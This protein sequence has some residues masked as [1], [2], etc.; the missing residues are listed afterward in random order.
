[1]RSASG[2]LACPLGDLAGAG[3]VLCEPPTRR[4]A[5]PMGGQPLE[6]SAPALLAEPLA[7]ALRVEGLAALVDQKHYMLARRGGVDGGRQ[8]GSDWDGWQ[9]HAG[10]LLFNVA[11]RIATHML[12]SHP[13]DIGA[14]QG[15]V[16]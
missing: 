7:E 12:A 8:F 15:S 13:Y 10:L 9:Q 16:E 4:L 3:A 5:Q 11:N 2:R 6:A 14:T 1:Y